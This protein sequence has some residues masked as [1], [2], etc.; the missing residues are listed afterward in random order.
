[1][2]SLYTTHNTQSTTNLEEKKC[3]LTSPISSKAYAQLETPKDSEPIQVKSSKK[4]KTLQSSHSTHKLELQKSKGLTS[5]HAF[6]RAPKIA[7][8]KDIYTK[9]AR[10]NQINLVSSRA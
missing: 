2:K 5:V 4:E 3:D 7:T 8:K 10:R 6:H 9:A 1:M